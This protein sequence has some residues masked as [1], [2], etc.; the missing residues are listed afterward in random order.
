MLKL[1]KKTEEKKEELMVEE[2]KEEDEPSST[3]SGPGLKLLGIGGKEVK[4]DTVKKTKKTTPG[5]IR[6][7]KDIAELDAGD[8]ASV[9]FPNPKDLTSFNVY[10]KPDQGYWKGARY[11]FTFNIPADYPHTPPTV[12]PFVYVILCTQSI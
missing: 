4:K 12:I 7:Q 1:K 3:S 10:V 8:V 9:E 11:H 2:G 5:E 6:I